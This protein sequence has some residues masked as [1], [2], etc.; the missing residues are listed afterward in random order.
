MKT[1]LTIIVFLWLSALTALTAK[2]LDSLRVETV[3][4]VKYI[5][6]KVDAGETLF[7]LSKR[8]KTTPTDITKAN[9]LKANQINLGQVIR[10]PLVL[11][12]SDSVKNAVSD[13][14][15]VNEAHANA[16][17][18]D[19]VK[20]SV[21][22][23]ASGETLAS[24]AK[25]Y[26]VTTAQLTKWN[27]LKS[28][29][30]ITNQVLIVDENAVAKPYYKLNGVETQLPP[31]PQ[32]IE[33]AKADVI[34][35]SGVAVVDESMQ[36]AHAEAPVGTIIKVIN[37]DNNQQCLVKVTSKLDTTK[38]SNILLLLGKD[39]QQ[40]LG[41]SEATIRVKLIYAVKP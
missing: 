8:Y 16:Q 38:F 2:P 7:S 37:L 32:N 9:E 25:K 39:A 22:T 15:K 26:K 10:I 20:I 6:H 12:A 27:S 35:Q 11:S 3:K 13:S 33:L 30:V 17:A 1:A 5:M 28:A 29:K 19:N 31:V 21:H 4:G 40:K 36:V 34:E 41:A 24:I 14:S 23:V 18:E